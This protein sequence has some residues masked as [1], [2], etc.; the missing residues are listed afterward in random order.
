ML[1]L[2]LLVVPVV[3]VV[4]PADRSATHT[5]SGRSMARDPQVDIGSA[6]PLRSALAVIHRWRLPFQQMMLSL[7]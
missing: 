2:A 7:S 6:P 5:R 4:P 1:G 3:P